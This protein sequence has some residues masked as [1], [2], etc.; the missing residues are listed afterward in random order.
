MLQST[1]GQHTTLTTLHQFYQANQ[2][3]QQKAIVNSARPD[4]N[5]EAFMRERANRG[6]KIMYDV[7]SELCDLIDLQTPCDRA[8]I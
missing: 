3:S 6:E 2:V 4:L 8:T 5:L 7:R 1:A